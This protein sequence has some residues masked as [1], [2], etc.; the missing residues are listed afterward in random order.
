M[1][2]VRAVVWETKAITIIGVMDTRMDRLRWTGCAQPALFRISPDETTASD[3][4][5]RDL[6]MHISSHHQ[7]VVVALVTAAVEEEVQIRNYQI[8]V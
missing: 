7:V 5:Y 2:N 3:A 6:M 1:L 8:R 4:T